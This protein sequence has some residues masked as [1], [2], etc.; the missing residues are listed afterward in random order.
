[1]DTTQKQE[2]LK[3]KAREM[4]AK[5]KREHELKTLEPDVEVQLLKIQNKNL[6]ARINFLESQDKTKDKRIEEQEV[7]IVASEAKVNG[8]MAFLLD[9]Q[10]TTSQIEQPPK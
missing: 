1:M 6:K 2:E 3:K 8:L 9:K 4:S 10:E 7:R 5:S